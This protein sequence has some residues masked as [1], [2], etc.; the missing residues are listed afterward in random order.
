VLEPSDAL[1]AIGR[2]LTLLGSRLHGVHRPGGGAPRA[3]DASETTVPGAA[4]PRD[5][6][7]P[8]QLAVLALG[9]LKT[10]TGSSAATW[11]R[12]RAASGRTCR[13]RNRQLGD[14]SA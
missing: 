3:H 6:L 8:R 4:I 2:V 11:S 14:L 5:G 10:P 1:M 9:G 7:G 12:P 13:A